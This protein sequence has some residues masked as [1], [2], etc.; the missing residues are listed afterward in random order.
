VGETLDE[1]RHKLLVTKRQA[2]GLRLRD[3][4]ERKAGA[5]LEHRRPRNGRI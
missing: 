3:A 4:V 1:L 5:L 2:R